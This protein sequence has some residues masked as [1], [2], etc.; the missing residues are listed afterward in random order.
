MVYK[1]HMCKMFHQHELLNMLR[2][3]IV[4]RTGRV[5]VLIDQFLNLS[6]PISL[7]PYKLQQLRTKNSIS[8]QKR[9]PDD[10]LHNNGNKIYLIND[11][12]WCWVISILCNIIIHHY[13]N[14]LI[15]YSISMNYL[16]CMTNIS[17]NK[18]KWFCNNNH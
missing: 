8:G 11:F 16:I 12:I 15:W 1:V 14:V 5:K 17:L 2:L 4:Y 10:L 7:S 13:Y 3:C 18:Q 6:L 9:L